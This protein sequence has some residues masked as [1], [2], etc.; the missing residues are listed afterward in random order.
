MCFEGGTLRVNKGLNSH[1]QVSHTL[2]LPTN[3]QSPSGYKFGATYVGTKML[4]P[5]EVIIRKILTKLQNCPKN[6]QS[7][8]IDRKGNLVLDCL[9]STR[10]YDLNL[11]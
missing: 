6:S 11:F 2:N 3:P 8:R 9:D 4:S 10:N 5:T 1:F 7:R